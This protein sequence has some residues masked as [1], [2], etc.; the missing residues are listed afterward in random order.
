[1][2]IAGYSAACR[3]RADR[4]PK[5]NGEEDQ[6]RGERGRS[7]SPYGG[8]LIPKFP[9]DNID[10]LAVMERRLELCH[11]EQRGGDGVG[12]DMAFPSGLSRALIDEAQHALHVQQWFPHRGQ[13]VA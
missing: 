2:T 11:V 9:G 5:R 10:D 7:V 6:S 3:R 4:G 12:R 13:W 1:M 8:C